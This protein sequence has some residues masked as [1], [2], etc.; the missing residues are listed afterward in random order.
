[1]PEEERIRQLGIRRVTPAN[2]NHY[3]GY[4]SIPPEN[5]QHH[6]QLRMG[7]PD[8][9]DDHIPE[10]ERRDNPLAERT[11]RLLLPGREK[12]AERFREASAVSSACRLRNVPVTRATRTTT[13]GTVETE[14]TAETKTT[15]TTAATTTK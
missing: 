8:N 12:E 1:M 10:E 14:A 15:G 3:L 9:L 2:P 13:V 11:P 5:T 7:P 4:S 6:H